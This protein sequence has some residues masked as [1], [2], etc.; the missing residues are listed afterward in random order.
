MALFYVSDGVQGPIIG[1]NPSQVRYLALS[2]NT[3]GLWVDPWIGGRDNVLAVTPS[4]THTGP[5]K[6]LRM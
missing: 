1:C 2:V 3:P 5:N 6:N 4:S